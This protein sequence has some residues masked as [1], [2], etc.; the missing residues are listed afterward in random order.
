MFFENCCISML[1]TFVKTKKNQDDIF[2][3]KKIGKQINFTD[4]ENELIKSF[5][6][7]K[8]EL[9]NQLNMEI[10]KRQICCEI[11]RK[12]DTHLHNES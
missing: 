8:E 7:D 9:M 2:Y 4:K 1:D 6:N 3:L 10:K 5:I 11:Q 12:I